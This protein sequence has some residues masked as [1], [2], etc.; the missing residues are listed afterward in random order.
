M[1]NCLIPVSLG[2]LYDKFSILLIKSEKISDKTK[3]LEVK[4]EISLLEPY[5]N[6]F[7]LNNEMRE[8]IKL[9]NEKL[10][11]IEDSIR[12]KEYKNEFDEEFIM[13]ARSVYITNDERAKI[14]N[15][16]NKILNSE[17][18]EI[19]SYANYKL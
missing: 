19:K 2:E 13:L 11:S 4:R 10:W 8:N 5:I 9:V 17:I 7:N 1:N 3:L 15:E 14:K 12:L 6:K 18:N 16:I